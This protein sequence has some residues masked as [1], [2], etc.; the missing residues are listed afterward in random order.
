MT[1]DN[2][3]DDFIYSQELQYDYNRFIASFT[4]HK[5]I[6]AQYFAETLGDSRAKD[7]IMEEAEKLIS[8]YNI[9]VDT[10]LQ[11]IQSDIDKVFVP[12]SSR[13]HEDVYEQALKQQ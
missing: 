2:E 3:Y 6:L 10:L 5:L 12:F 1:N 11:D 7:K 4:P 9:T 8:K 13:D